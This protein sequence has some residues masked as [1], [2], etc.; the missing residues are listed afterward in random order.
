MRSNH[1]RLGRSQATQRDA[2]DSALLTGRTRHSSC[3]PCA[4]GRPA[5][6]GA[7]IRKMGFLR[8]QSS[9]D[10]KPI[11]VAA[12][13]WCMLAIWAVSAVGTAPSILMEPV[14]RGPVA[15][16]WA[17]ALGTFCATWVVLGRLLSLTAIS[18]ATSM[19]SALGIWLALT[20][21]LPAGRHSDAC[22][23]EGS[24]HG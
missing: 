15:T 18:R 21:S 16:Q 4:M 11:L 20:L 19:L 13:R 24:P 6:G 12:F 3:C 22:E 7:R 5:A 9:H 8:A 2:E 23:P 10:L 14:S 17:V 1:S